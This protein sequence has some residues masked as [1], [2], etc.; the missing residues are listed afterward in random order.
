MFISNGFFKYAAFGLVL[1]VSI[2]WFSVYGGKFLVN[3]F[4]KS[5][6]GT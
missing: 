2:F 4:K 6:S 3:L 1:I 5:I